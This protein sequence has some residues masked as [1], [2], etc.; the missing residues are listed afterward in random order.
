M[1]SFPFGSFANGAAMRIG[2]LAMFLSPELSFEETY[3][4]ASEAVVSSHVHPDAVDVCAVLCFVCM[5]LMKE[6]ADSLD[7]ETF[8]RNIPC[9]SERS[10]QKLDEILEGIKSKEEDDMKF[11]SKVSATDFQVR[12]FV[13]HRKK[14]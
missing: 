3:Y 8:I 14:Y 11:L 1:A 13:S 6:S 7:I 5:K 12:P 10:K 4:C 2:P 9:K